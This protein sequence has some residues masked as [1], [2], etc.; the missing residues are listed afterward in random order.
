VGPWPAVDRRT[1]CRRA[2]RRKR[3]WPNGLGECNGRRWRSNCY[4]WVLTIAGGDDH[5][6]HAV[7]GSSPDLLIAVRRRSALAFKAPPVSAALCFCG[8]PFP[9][10]ARFPFARPVSLETRIGKWDD[11]S[12]GGRRDRKRIRSEREG[13]DRPRMT[14]IL[15]AIRRVQKGPALDRVLFFLAIPLHFPPVPGP[16]LP[17]LRGGPPNWL[18]RARAI[19]DLRPTKTSD[20]QRVGPMARRT[21]QGGR[22]RRGRRMFLFLRPLWSAAGRTR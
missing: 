20:P 19:S 11:E 14:M 7:T 3:W 13:R 18:S 8:G 5:V 15:S 2:V 1:F 12:L 6:R 9:P 22:R 21:H 10:P 4:S 16:T 17:R